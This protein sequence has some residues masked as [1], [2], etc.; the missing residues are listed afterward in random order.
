MADY[1]KVVYDE[2][3]HPYTN[4]PE[5]LVSYLFQSFQMKPGM[6]FLEPGCGRGDFLLNFQKLGLDCYGVDLSLEAKTFLAKSKIPVEICNADKDRLPF[7]DD[8]FDIIYNKSFLEH[9]RE[10]DHFLKEARRILKPGG[11]ILCLV[12]DWE[13][14]YKIYFDDFTHRTPF[15]KVSL[16]DIFKICDFSNINVY[17]FRQLPIVWKYPILNYFCAMISPF[18]PV[19]TKNKFFRWSRE[20]ML[21]GSAYKETKV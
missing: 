3:S 15:T 21:V 8:T 11:L 13:S 2:K 10:P 19:R 7:D 20:L 16:N 1:L 17:I 5:Q 4:Y 9:L 18:I 6:K 14:N 12:P